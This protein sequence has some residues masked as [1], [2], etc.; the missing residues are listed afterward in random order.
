MK[1]LKKYFLYSLL[2]IPVLVTGMDNSH[3]YKARLFPG[4]PRF[5]EP[6]L[7]TFDLVLTGG[8]TTTSR[9]GCGKKVP[10]FDLFG[11]QKLQFL[12]VNVPNFDTQNSLNQLVINLANLPHSPC[13]AELE[14]GANFDMIEAD[15]YYIQNFT[16]GFFFRAHIPVR[17]FQISCVKFCDLSPTSGITNNQTPEWQAFLQN[18][19]DILALHGLCAHSFTKTY[20]G[21]LSL[22]LGWTMN[23]EETHH[24]DYIDTTIQTGGLFP[25]GNVRSIHNI[26]DIPSGYN[27]HFAIPVIFDF[28]MG[29]FEWLTLGAHLDALFFFDATHK[30]RL[31]TDSCTNGL[32]KLGVG[33]VKEKSGTLW[34]TSAYIKADH[35]FGGLSLQFGYAFDRK[36]RDFL[37]PCSSL[38]NCNIVNSDSM[39]DSW[40]M[41]TLQCIVDYD[42]ATDH[43]PSLP[44]F[45]LVFNHVLG[46][47]HIFDTPLNGIFIGLDWSWCYS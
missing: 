20:P 23:Y 37:T 24:L 14:L 5:E 31:K 3:F 38:F 44:H 10:L 34:D 1:F 8:H 29:L 21:D 27:G 11:P 47:R 25:T 16:H 18:F 4:E 45:S 2:L 22:L 13:F 41:H 15:F 39:L 46:G 19:N 6:W 7:S 32:I 33:C 36:E 42:F 35:F 40:R 30:A 26:L 28:S 43:C 12:G 9:D 17:R